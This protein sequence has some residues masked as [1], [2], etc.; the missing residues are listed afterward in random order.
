MRPSLQPL[1]EKLGTQNL[2]E[3]YAD[4]MLANQS[5]LANWLLPII[6][7]NQQPYKMASWR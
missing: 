3:F 6:E 2:A 1:A 4:V 7:A 5:T